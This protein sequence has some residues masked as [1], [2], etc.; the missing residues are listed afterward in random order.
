[1]RVRHILA[2]RNDSHFHTQ[3][4]LSPPSQTLTTF[5]NQDIYIRASIEKSACDDG[6]VYQSVWSPVSVFPATLDFSKIKSSTFYVPSYL[7]SAGNTYRV[8]YTLEHST[9]PTRSLELMYDFTV[10]F[11]PLV[12]AISGGTQSQAT[13]LSEFH[14]DASISTDPDEPEEKQTRGLTYKWTCSLY[15]STTDSSAACVTLAGRPLALTNTAVVT[16]PA[17][18]LAVTT[19][20]PYTFTV[21]VSKASKKAVTATKYMHVSA[22][23]IPVVSLLPHASL[24][25][26]NG[27]I[28]VNAVDQVI[29]RGSCKS[30]ANSTDETMAYKWTLTDASG[31]AIDTSDA[32]VFTLST[33]NLN[34][35]M[36]GNSGLI[37]GGTTVRKC[38]HVCMY[39][40]MWGA[41][42]SL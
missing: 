24:S 3:V 5:R 41:V 15:D 2:Q 28:Y 40:W 4:T 25:R 33:N 9:D 12:A 27:G 16:I 11:Q 26:K 38:M 18:T 19:T 13:V 29:F 6:S 14:I 20:E 31:K 10:G 36:L 39:A 21:A 17:G 34:F 1:M 30:T 23:P 32:N 37:S 35:V 7:L 8:K 42:Y 22:D